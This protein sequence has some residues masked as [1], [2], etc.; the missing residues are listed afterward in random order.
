MPYSSALYA[1]AVVGATRVGRKCLFQQHQPQ[2][3]YP[4]RLHIMQLNMGLALHQGMLK[5]LPKVGSQ[6]C[7]YLNGWCMEVLGR[8]YSRDEHPL[9]ILTSELEEHSSVCLSVMVHGNVR[10]FPFPTCRYIVRQIKPPF[11]RTRSTIRRSN[12]SDPDTDQ[13]E[14]ISVPA[15]RFRNS[16]DLHF[17]F[18]Y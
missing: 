12:R 14:F 9:G 16:V 8:L 6:V 2:F 18:K 5:H 17:K 10:R 15:H 4:L 11:S 1:A 13:S 3:R 7:R